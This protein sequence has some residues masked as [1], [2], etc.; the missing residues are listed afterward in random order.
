M[1]GSKH[2]S[3][4]PLGILSKTQPYKAL[5]PLYHGVAR[6]DDLRVIIGIVYVIRKSSEKGRSAPGRK[7]RRF[8][9]CKDCTPLPPLVLPILLLT[10]AI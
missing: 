6:V 7:V 5:F 10:L 4:K 2:S 9:I 3:K 8:F 1:F